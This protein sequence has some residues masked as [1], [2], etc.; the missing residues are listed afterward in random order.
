MK[1]PVSSHEECLYDCVQSLLSAEPH[2]KTYF[3][4]L[5]EREQGHIMLHSD[6]ICSMTDLESFVRQIRT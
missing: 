3:M 2:A 4:S 5:D 1:N 6:T